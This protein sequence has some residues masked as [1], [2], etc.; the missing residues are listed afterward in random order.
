M[1]ERAA[2][3][4][5]LVGASTFA[6]AAVSTLAWAVFTSQ[7]VTPIRAPGPPT[8]RIASIKRIAPA[9]T[10]PDELIARAAERDP[11]GT[12]PKA[13]AQSS[14]LAIAPIAEQQTLR[15]LGTVIDSLGGSFVFCQLGATSPVLLRVGQR[16]GG[17]EL[18]RVEKGIAEFASPTG[19][20][21]ERQ[22]PRAGA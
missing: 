10:T 22:V 12:K 11:F 21:V 3:G 17:F 13:M 15:V 19:D 1:N 2:V 14:A 7:P 9:D 8:G 6:A 18:R 5:A 16:I 4:T 20:R